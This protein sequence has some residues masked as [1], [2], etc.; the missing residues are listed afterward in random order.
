VRSP[1]GPARCPGTQPGSHGRLVRR[2][3]HEP[4]L[5]AFSDWFREA[6]LIAAK[7]F[8]DNTRHGLGE[9]GWESHQLIHRIWA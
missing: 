4:G 5:C 6:A 1:S 9:G 7:D 3:G 8:K 2:P